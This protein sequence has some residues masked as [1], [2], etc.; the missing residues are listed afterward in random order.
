MQVTEGSIIVTC[1]VIGGPGADLSSSLSLFKSKVPGMTRTHIQLQQNAVKWL[2]YFDTYE[3]TQIT[4]FFFYVL[5]LMNLI[6]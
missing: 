1:D 4:D 2:D 6:L 5:Q 3:L